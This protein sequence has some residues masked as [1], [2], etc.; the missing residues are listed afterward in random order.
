MDY[1]LEIVLEAWLSKKVN[2][3]W[4][5]GETEATNVKVKKDKVLAVVDRCK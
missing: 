3:V 1:D 4:F 2:K 5:C